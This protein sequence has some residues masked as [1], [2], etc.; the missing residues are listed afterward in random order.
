[1]ESSKAKSRLF[2]SSSQ[3]CSAVQRSWKP[4][5]D[6]DDCSCSPQ[7]PDLSESFGMD[8]RWCKSIQL[9]ALFMFYAICIIYREREREVSLEV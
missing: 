9:T 7:D 2:F 8:Y 5:L 1:M 4:C 6:W 3:I